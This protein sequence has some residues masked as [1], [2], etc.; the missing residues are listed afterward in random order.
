[1]RY[2]ASLLHREPL[3]SFSYSTVTDFAEFIGLT[4]HYFDMPQRAFPSMR[5]EQLQRY[6][7]PTLVLPAEHDVFYDAS[8]TAEVARR[9]LKNGTVERLDGLGQAGHRNT[10]DC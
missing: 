3:F 9:V 7:A 8:S 5:A 1:M 4:A 6:T 2:Q 10:D